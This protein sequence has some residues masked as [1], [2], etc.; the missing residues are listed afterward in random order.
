[1]KVE[2]RDEK[3]IVIFPET[4]AEQIV[5]QRFVGGMVSTETPKPFQQNI[6]P[7]IVEVKRA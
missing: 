2:M 5:I 7:L 1:M 4:T 3:T 6:V